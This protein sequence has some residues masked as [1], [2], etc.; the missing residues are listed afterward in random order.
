MIQMDGDEDL[1]VQYELIENEGS[2][3]GSANQN[4]P[5][6]G[7]EAGGQEV[8]A[9]DDGL[10]AGGAG[11]EARA[12]SER[13]RKAEQLEWME[14]PVCLETPRSGPI[15]TCRKGHMVCSVCQP[16]VS[17]C[18]TCRDSHTDCRSIIAEKLLARLLQDT[19]VSCKHRGSGCG[20]E[21]LVARLGE[22][23]E[24]CMYRA[25]RCPA[26]HRG[27]CSWT[28]P[29]NKLIQ[30]VIH[31]KCAQVVKSKPPNSFVSTIGDFAQDQTV[32]SKT[33]PTHWKPVMLI[34]PETLK[35]FCYAIFYRDASGHWLSYVRS[36]APPTVTS[37]LRA[38]IRVGPCGV[39]RTKGSLQDHFLY[40][41]RV[42]SSEATESEVQESGDY[43]LLRDGQVRKLRTDKTIMEYSITLRQVEQSPPPCP[44]PPNI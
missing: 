13:K 28:G 19:P 1:M 37:G 24:G 42:A 21:A 30:H 12:D 2:P 20:F 6:A 18:P 32:F 29:L 17:Q 41:G 4:T 9:G 40:C 10:V 11:A 26:S 3:D 27:A 43:L 14:C 16:Q 34:S 22:H 33:T 8:D 36:F 7:G 31:Q 39:A 5:Y 44:D 25:V 15:Y 23:E 38:E 35:F